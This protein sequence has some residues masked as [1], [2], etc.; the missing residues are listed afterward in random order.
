[1]RYAIVGLGIGSALSKISEEEF[2]R[3]RLAKPRILGPLAIEEKFDL[4]IANYED[5]ASARLA[6]KRDASLAVIPIPRLNPGMEQNPFDLV[7][8]E[9]RKDQR[10]TAQN[11]VQDAQFRAD[12]WR[13]EQECSS[14]E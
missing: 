2:L 6:V 7:E 8:N 3:V 4:V 5:F 14:Q 10:M 9:P 1:M 13:L 11:N 12:L